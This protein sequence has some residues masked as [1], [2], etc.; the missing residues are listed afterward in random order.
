[1][2]SRLLDA[3][4][5]I[6]YTG[7]ILVFSSE[8]EQKDGKLGLK[9]RGII[10][11]RKRRKEMTRKQFWPGMLAIALIFAMMI[12][13]CDSGS[14]SPSPGDNPNPNDTS[15]AGIYLG[16]I[17][18]NDRLTEKNISLLENDTKSEFQ[19]FIND[20]G[21]K[22][23]TALYYAVDNSIDRLEKANLRDDVVNVSI[24]TFT[25]GLDNV[26]IDLNN[27]YDSRDAYR[28]Y[29]RTRINTVK[30]N[31]ILPIYA[32][33]IGMK[34]PDVMDD[35]AFSEGIAALASSPPENYFYNLAN[36]TEVNNTFAQIAKSLSTQSQTQSI[37]L[38]IPGGYEDGTKMQF[39]FDNI[40]PNV[41]DSKFCIEG[42]YKR[43]NYR[44]LEDV[45]YKGLTSSS[46]PPVTGKVVDK[47]FVEFT[48][49]NVVPDSGSK[50]PTE[51]TKQWY[52]T[53]SIWQINSEFGKEG[54]TVT[55]TDKKSSVIILI[56]DCTTSLGDS[57]FNSMKTA[58][59]RFID[60]LLSN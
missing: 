51:N 24:V 29:L 33:S 22:D 47:A 34:G 17:G 40:N 38:K 10:F 23:G 6:L 7:N 26:S 60:V 37:K 49:E 31:K 11:H 58:A 27:K 2:S 21:M 25:D 20:M 18:F 28:D 48:F 13:G 50:V 3:N 59:N 36:M 43:G 4:N 19:S 15:K 57:N 46:K 1:M 56:L 55:I 39:I 45:V 32:Y 35:T 54:D 14:S 30:I 12:A 5:Y 53:G 16:I 42:T 9:I 8:F 41:S 52:Y 44:Q